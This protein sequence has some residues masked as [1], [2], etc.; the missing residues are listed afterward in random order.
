M[1]PNREIYHEVAEAIK[2]CPIPIVPTLSSV[3][4]CTE[5]IREFT[6]NGNSYFVDEVNCGFA[7]G[8]VL[9]RPSIFDASREIPG[10]DREGVAVTLKGKS[11]VLAADNVHEALEKAG[12]MFPAADDGGIAR[13][14]EKSLRC[15]RLSCCDESDRSPA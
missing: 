3:S 9:K 15:D 7:L 6:E 14:G 1:H 2:T 12:F 10:Y 8:K 11:G 4:T 5:E 13:R